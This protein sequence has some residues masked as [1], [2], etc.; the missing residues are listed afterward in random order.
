MSA[1]WAR[2]TSA[3]S[4]TAFSWG[5]PRTGRS[6]WDGIHS[7]NMAAVTLYNGQKSSGGYSRPRTTPRPARS[8]SDPIPEFRDGRRHNLKL[9]SRVVRSGT[10][11]PSVLY[12]QDRRKDLQLAQCGISPY[13][14]TLPILLCQRPTVTTRPPCGMATCGPAHRR[15]SLRPDPQPAAGAAYFYN[16]DRSYPGRRPR[17]RASSAENR[18]W[19]TNFFLQGSL[20]K[21]SD[22]GY[23][24]VRERYVCQPTCT[25]SPIRGST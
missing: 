1:A 3:S 16:S 14:R 18:Q 19:D 12:E 4:T 15:R 2:S 17:G 22:G 20:N 23:P 11:N 10:V 9:T 13:D 24:P 21:A 5:M 7:S 25:T 6:T 8:T